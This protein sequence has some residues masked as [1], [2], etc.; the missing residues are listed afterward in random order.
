VLLTVGP[1]M[2]SASSTYP[3]VAS[4][5]KDCTNKG[6]IILRTDFIR[7]E[8]VRMSTAPVGS[9]VG[10][11]VRTVR[12]LLTDLESEV[13][14]AAVSPA[15]RARWAMVTVRN[16]SQSPRGL[17]GSTAVCTFD[18][19]TGRV[20]ASRTGGAKT[21]PSGQ[22]VII[23]SAGFKPLAHLWTPGQTYDV[24]RVAHP[25]GPML[26]FEFTDTGVQS[27]RSYRVNAYHVDHYSDGEKPL[28]SVGLEC[29]GQ[30]KV[31]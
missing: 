24:L 25:G 2:A 28:A 3:S 19:V 5:T 20:I 7:F 18:Y 17:L 1:A 6:S 4:G 31:G 14:W 9:P 13:S 21:C 15:I 23:T 29:S 10:G 8:G 22:T 16:A 27:I 30:E 26:G 11:W 12:P